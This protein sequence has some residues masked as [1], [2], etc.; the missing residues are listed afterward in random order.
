MTKSITSLFIPFKE[1][2]SGIKIPKQFT[3]PFNYTPHPLSVLASKELQEYLNTQTDWEH[4]FG[5]NAKE[6]ERFYGKMFGVLVVKNQ[7]NQLGYLAAFSGI[8]AKQTILKHFVPPVFDRKSDTSFYTQLEEEIN[9]LNQQVK[10]LK[11]SSDYEQTISNHNHL[12]NEAEELLSRKKN[13]L[14]TAKKQRQ[15]QR[16]RRTKI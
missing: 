13:E 8:L 14:K 3:F 12:T 10:S 5:L 7:N 16:K 2:I 15:L 9:E 1:P 4:N 6:N 11:S